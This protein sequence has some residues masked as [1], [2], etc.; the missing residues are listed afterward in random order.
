MRKKSVLDDDETWALYNIDDSFAE[1]FF[2]AFL[3][4]RFLIILQ[5]TILIQGL[6]KVG[7][8]LFFFTLLDIKMK[9]QQYIISRLLFNLRLTED[10]FNLTKIKIY[11]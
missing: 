7:N 9:N 11:K 1:G 10:V 6:L 4:G 3:N 2:Q 8:C 5:G